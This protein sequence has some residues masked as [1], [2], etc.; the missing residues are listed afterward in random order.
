MVA[1]VS[2]RRRHSVT[3]IRPSRFCRR[4][5]SDA[6]AATRRADEGALRGVAP[7]RP[8]PQQRLLALDA[9]GDDVSPRLCARSIVDSDD[10]LVL[11]A[12][13]PGDE[14]SVDLQLVDRQAPQVAERRIAGAEVVDDDGGRPFRA[15]A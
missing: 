11:A 8:Q 9:L 6:S 14:R 1:W 5:Q 12:H 3:R 7:H 2:R 13:E 15:A 4:S 10:D